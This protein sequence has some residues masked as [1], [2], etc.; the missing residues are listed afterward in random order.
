MRSCKFL[1]KPITLDESNLEFHV[2]EQHE[3]FINNFINNRTYFRGKPIIVTHEKDNNDYGEILNRPEYKLS[4]F[5]HIVSRK[6]NKNSK[7]RILNIKRLQSC[8][9]VKELIDITN[10]FGSNCQTCQYYKLKD[11]IEHN[12]EVTYIYCVTCRYVVIL[13]KA[14]NDKLPK[15]HEEYEYYFIKS[16][17]YVDEQPMHI[18]ILKKF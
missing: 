10:S 2:K 6:I 7:K 14:I 12:N 18:S 8:Q 11:V 3:K 9:W 17:F 4:S 16:A 13:Q 5:A 15:E 1:S